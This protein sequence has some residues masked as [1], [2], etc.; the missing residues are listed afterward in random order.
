VLGRGDNARI[1]P[2][3]EHFTIKLPLALEPEERQKRKKKKS[4][5]IAIF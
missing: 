4:E 2:G 1:W 3:R 5:L